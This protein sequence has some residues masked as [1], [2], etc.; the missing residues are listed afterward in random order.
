MHTVLRQHV[1]P[2]CSTRISVS[3]A[4]QA[5]LQQRWQQACPSC[6]VCQLQQQLDP[7]ASAG[8]RCMPC[9]AHPLVVPKVELQG[10]TLYSQ[11]KPCRPCLLCT[12]LP[13]A[14]PQ[15]LLLAAVQRHE[16][17]KK[18]FATPFHGWIAIAATEQS[19]CSGLLAGQLEPAVPAQVR[20]CHGA[21]QAQPVGRC[22]L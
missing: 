6:H 15:Q 14:C 19:H 22:T 16:F 12:Q 10:S 8:A 1:A 5:V 11:A 4:T 17:I 2:S 20:V 18:V 21:W 7:A 13:R 9:S 3:T